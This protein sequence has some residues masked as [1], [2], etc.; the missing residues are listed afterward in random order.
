MSELEKIF[1]TS[2]LTIG[3]G[4]TVYVIGQLLSKF[5]IEPIHELRKV[6]GEVRFALAFHAPTIN[7]PI[8]RTQVTS[9]KAYDALMKCSADLLVRA[10]GIPLY[11]VISRVSFRFVPEKKK[12]ADAAKWLR[13]LSTHVHESGE[14]AIKNLQEI[15]DRIERIQQSLGISSQT[16]E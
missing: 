6:I 2:G 12:V 7:T 13:G 8:S 4:V 10:E 14:K 9:D 15:Q 5:V 11:G 1:L 3:G 16:E